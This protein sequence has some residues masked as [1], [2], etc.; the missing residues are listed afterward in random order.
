MGCS[1]YWREGPEG[2][3]D[4]GPRRKVL[5]RSPSPPP[6]PLASAGVP[7]SGAALVPS[8]RGQVQ[9]D[10]GWGPWCS[11]VRGSSGAGPN[12][13]PSLC[14]GQEVCSIEAGWA[15]L[16]Q[17][18][19]RARGARCRAGGWE[20]PGAARSSTHPV[21]AVPGQR[22][23]WRRCARTLQTHLTRG[24]R[25]RSQR[26]LTAHHPPRAQQAAP[27]AHTHG[28]PIC[29]LPP[30]SLRGDPRLPRGAHTPSLRARC[31]PTAS[32]LSSRPLS[33]VATAP[34][35]W[36]HPVSTQICSGVF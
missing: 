8:G 3:E 13:N 2:L 25:H 26:M 24:H 33:C 18:A 34:S 23:G 7:P 29:D 21:V 27:S 28:R 32:F 11:G 15:A 10:S 30:A 17:G 19:C 31:P 35:P 20:V 16:E 36:P 5:T 14:G 22:G 6:R 9:T 4:P 1:D 12:P